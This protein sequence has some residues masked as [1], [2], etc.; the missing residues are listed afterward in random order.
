MLN[1]S[2]NAFVECIS[3]GYKFGI[4]RMNNTLLLKMMLKSET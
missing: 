3:K 1:E 2:L 4:K